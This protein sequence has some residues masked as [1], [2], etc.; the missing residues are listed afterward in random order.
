M[1]MVA[2]AFIITPALAEEPEMQTPDL[3][4]ETPATLSL[5]N[6]DEDAVKSDGEANWYVGMDYAGFSF[7]IPAGTMVEKNSK[8]LARYPDGSFG[9]SMSNVAK[10]GSNQKIAKQ[11]CTELA[12]TLKLKDEKVEGVKFGKCSGAKAT[13]DME[14]QK[15]TLLVLPYDGEEMTTVIIANDNRTNWVDHLLETLKR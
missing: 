3:T 5:Q 6:P 11:L 1:A 2:A 8:L 14:G 13:G 15:V 4:G 9:V 7:E 12:R 10:S